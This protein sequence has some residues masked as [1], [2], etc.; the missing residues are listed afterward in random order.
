MDRLGKKIYTN[1]RGYE[2]HAV[3]LCETNSKR[4]SIM[5]YTVD[6]DG[7]MSEPVTI[8]RKDIIKKKDICDLLYDFEGDFTEDDIKEVKSELQCMLKEGDCC[9]IQ[10]KATPAEL[11]VAISRYIFDNAEKLDDNPKAE[12]FIKEG[13]GYLKTTKIE[14]F[15]K[16]YKE[17]TG[18]SKRQDVLKL[19]KIMGV[20]KNANNRSYDMVV[21]MAGEKI[22][23][24]KLELADIKE[25]EQEDEV[26]GQCL[27]DHTD[28]M[29]VS[30]EL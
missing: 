11:H 24:Y 9:E 17:S 27:S 21:S 26:I 25:D 16:E 29:A 28:G 19:L 15:I 4:M 8:T 30:S 22:R 23:Y 1:A 10:S 20:L 2:V 14:E 5:L 3:K 18:Y 7:R 12:I 13:D 6:P